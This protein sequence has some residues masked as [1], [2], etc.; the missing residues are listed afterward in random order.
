M[1]LTIQTVEGAHTVETGDGDCT[2]PPERRHDP[3][4]SRKIQYA[5]EAC[6]GLSRERTVE[7]L[8]KVVRGH[9][10][11]TQ[12]IEDIPGGEMQDECADKFGYHMRYRVAGIGYEDPLLVEYRSLA[13]RI[14]DCV[15]LLEA[16]V[17]EKHDR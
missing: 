1:K 7:V 6:R 16:K 15:D 2:D 3:E 8:R 4:L 5:N 10:E 14:W 13:R 17:R 11:H 12:R 9:H